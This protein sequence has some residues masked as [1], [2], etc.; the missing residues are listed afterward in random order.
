MLN[1]ES[2]KFDKQIREK[3]QNLEA[4]FKPEDWKLMEQ[5]LDGDVA[6]ANPEFEDVLLDGIAYGSLENYKAEFDPN[7]WNLM[8]QK[9]DD[10]AFPLRRKLYRYKVAEVGL[11]LLAIFT[12]IQFLPFKK[13]K[14]QRNIAAF[15]ILSSDNGENS[16]ISEIE[17][18]SKYNKALNS[19]NLNAADA[20]GLGLENNVSINGAPPT[21]G[22]GIGESAN[23]NSHAGLVVEHD[24]SP[25]TLNFSVSDL[26]LNTFSKKY[27]DLSVSTPPLA[28]NHK[29]SNRPVSLLL[30]LNTYKPGKLSVANQSSDL[31][32]CASC[33]TVASGLLVSIGMMGG[34]DADYITTPYDNEYHQNEF[35]QIAMGYSGGISLGFRYH[36]WE[37]ETGAV[38]ASK[39]YGSRNIFEINGSFS[40]GG[41]VKE[42]LLDVQLDI[43]KIPVHLR[44][45]FM[46]QSKW[47]IYA[48]S[49]ASF[50]VTVETLY[51]YTSYAVGNSNALAS[52][53]SNPHP[54][55]SF[56]GVF[57][58][59]DL[60]DNTFITANI[61]VGIERYFNSR[62]SIFLGST[63]QHQITKGMGPQNDKINSLSIM[64]GARVT[65][66]SSKK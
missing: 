35:G 15:E 19:Q 20:N 36:K 7:H 39:Y 37:L 1:M 13:N 49:G 2:N 41:Y 11:M 12:L 27:L 47:N 24:E 56:N 52:R 65:L 61:G 29:E 8:E 38:Y 55:K 60:I 33:K 17:S 5:K 53:R 32:E 48:H 50:N 21:D 54:T 26:K 46:N 59:G 51:E 23:H 58:G 40:D 63:Y 4:E 9:L 66:K 31:P 28:I 43:V 22:L 34:V 57:E 42:G 6:E 64:T 45:N 44:Y 18:I 30:P 62:M 3:L 25:E 10:Q 14:T 16:S